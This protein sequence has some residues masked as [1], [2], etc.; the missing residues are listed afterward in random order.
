VEPPGLFFLLAFLRSIVSNYC[1]ILKDS[2][3]TAMLFESSHQKQ[4]YREATN[5]VWHAVLR[6]H[7]SDQ[8]YT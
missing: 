2:I 6:G 4:V 1:T 5:V 8:F 3:V 7:F